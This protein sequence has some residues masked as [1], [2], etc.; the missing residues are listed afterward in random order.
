MLR[1]LGVM[2]NV[3]RSHWQVMS[4]GMML[5]DL[6]IWHRHIWI[7]KRSLNFKRNNTEEV[8]VK[9]QRKQHLLKGHCKK[10]IVFPAGKLVQK[11]L[12]EVGNMVF[13]LFP[14]FATRR[15]SHFL[16]F[17]AC[18]P[19]IFERLNCCHFWQLLQS[20]FV[21]FLFILLTGY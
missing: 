3:W 6:Q 4:R 2:E 17:P 5:S 16:L 19:L 12:L 20:L 10:K 21:A 15:L 9:W 14:S 13:G 18:L 8:Q 7:G 1:S 11:L